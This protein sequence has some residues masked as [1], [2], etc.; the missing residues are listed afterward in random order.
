MTSQGPLTA[1]LLASTPNALT[2]ATT[3]PFLAAAGR[4]TLPKP[5]LSQWLSQDR[6]YAQS[7]ILS[8]IHI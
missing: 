8:L 4:G 5:L 6:L 3:H 2:R 1:Y 7:Y